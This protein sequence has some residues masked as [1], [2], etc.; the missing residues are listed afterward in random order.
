[1]NA[2]G[3]GRNYAEA[4][5]TLARKSDAVE[6]WGALLDAISDGMRED[7]TLRAFLESPKLSASHKIE[8][9]EKGL[10]RRVPPVFLRFID[11]VINKRRQMLIPQIAS[12]YRLLIDEAEHRV[13]AT[14]IVASEPN[15][16]ERDA[17]ARQLTRLFGK[18]VVPHIT[19]NP[20]ILGGV[21]V[22]VGDTVMD[23]SVRRRL[24]MLRQRMLATVHR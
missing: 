20:A 13:H 15:E 1:M 17:L 3:I 2:E 9:L 22:K 8:I 6:E 7:A 21:I 19:L 23:G 24:S 12:E 18:R 4:L 11:T 16:P 5:L 14:V 10:K